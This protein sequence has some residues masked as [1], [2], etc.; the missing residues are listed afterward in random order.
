MSATAYEV[1]TPERTDAQRFEA[2]EH[3]NEIRS[4][5]AQLKRDLKYG[6]KSVLDVLRAPA[7]ELETMKVF[8][9]LL[10]MPKV[11]RVKAGKILART[12]C[13]MSKTVGGLSERQRGELIALLPRLGLR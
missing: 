5:R 4:Y 6:R 2:L 8:D 7:D 11:G 13:S 10:A 1:R 12:K 3:A 9:L